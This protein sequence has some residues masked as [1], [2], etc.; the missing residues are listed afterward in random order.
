MVLSPPRLWPLTDC[1]TNYRPVLSSERAP[2][3][4]EQSNC[5]AKKRKKKKKELVMSPKGVPETKTDKPNDS[6]SQ[7]QLNSTQ[8]RISN[9]LIHL[10]VHKK[11]TPWP[12]SASELYRPSDHR[13]SAKLVPNFVDRV[14]RIPSPYSWLSRPEPL[15]L[16]PSSS[17][18]ALTWLSRPRSITTIF[19]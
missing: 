13:L 2:H 7:H 1:T 12:Q 4:E 14:W 8:E 10:P 3:D 16:L 11:K 17:S 5:P 18:I 6:R 9:L 19:L 15:L